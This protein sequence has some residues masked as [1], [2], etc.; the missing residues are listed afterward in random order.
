MNRRDFIK[1]LGFGSLASAAAALL[2]APVIKALAAVPGP[3]TGWSRG[4]RNGD[5]L[6]FDVES[7]DGAFAHAT[8]Y[9]LLKTPAGSEHTVSAEFVG[10]DPPRADVMIP[11]DAEILETKIIVGSGG[12]IDVNVGVQSFEEVFGR[13]LTVE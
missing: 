6:T 2:P 8:V 11:F 5:V 4:I 7:V 12:P 1:A 10:E 13:N 9:A 3:L